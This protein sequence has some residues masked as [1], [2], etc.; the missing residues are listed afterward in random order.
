MIAIKPHHFVD[1]ITAFGEGRTQ[2]EPHP[3]GH[4]VHTV[5]AEIL[6]NPNV[7]LRIELGADS[8]CLPCRHNAD[9]LC[10]DTIDTSFRPQAPKSKREWNLRIDGRWCERL[11]LRQDDELTA[12]E[13]CL[14]IRERAGEITDIYCEIASER[15]ARRQANL[16]NGVA[17]FLDE[18]D[19]PRP[20]EA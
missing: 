6:A 15:T 3:Y 5:A 18:A 19:G 14:R 4:A 20:R 7:T 16:E 2:F 17:Q 9:G 8:I 13:F 12:R 11:G 10:D 1:I